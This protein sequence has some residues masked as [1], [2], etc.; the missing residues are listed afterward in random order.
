VT[1]RLELLQAE[2]FWLL[3]VQAGGQVLR[4][5]SEP[6]TVLTQQGAELVYREGLQP[7]T[8]GRS[9]D[10]STDFSVPVSVL[11]TEAWDVLVGSFVQIERAR[12]TIYRWHEGQTIER[13]TVLVDGFVSGF[14]YGE[15]DEPVQ[16]AVVRRLRSFSRLIPSPGM[17]VDESTWPVRG[18]FEVDEKIL[19]VTYPMVFGSPGNVDGEIVAATP[20]LLVEKNTVPLGAGDRLLIAGHKVFAAEV[21]IFDYTDEDTPVQ[22][23]LPVLHETDAVGRVCALV[24]PTGSGLTIEKGRTYYVGWNEPGLVRGVEPVL[25]AGDLIEWVLETW[26]DQRIDRARFAEVRDVLNAY[27]IDSYIVGEWTDPNEYLSAEILPLLPVE[28]RQGVEGIWYKLRRVTATRADSK[29]RLDADTRRI[30]RASR[31]TTESDSVVNEVTIEFAPDRATGR[32]RRRLIVGALDAF[33]DRD[34][35]DPEIEGVDPRM[36]GSY[37][38]KLSQQLFDRQPITLSAHSVYDPT[39]AARIAQDVIDQQALPRRAVDYTGETELEAFGEGDVVTLND[40]SVGFADVLAE[41]RD[42]VAGGAD[43]AVPLLLFDDPILIERL[44]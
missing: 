13:A 7:L 1:S 22:A 24:D 28:P 40:S 20:A 31:V 34:E 12:A 38:A 39:T 11:G 23:V 18:G 35:L 3:E 33:R 14:S 29:A 15:I 16:F 2:G 25:G 17:V 6:I 36:L 44:Q 32:F 30:Q 41:V 4:F 37:R 10:G 42:V 5:S 43:A 9:S 27:L 8:S 19:G 26:T 21:T